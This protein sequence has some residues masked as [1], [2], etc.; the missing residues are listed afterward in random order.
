MHTQRY[1][2][3]QENSSLSCPDPSQLPPSPQAAVSRNRGPPVNYK[4]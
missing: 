3:S 2:V 1:L 4:A